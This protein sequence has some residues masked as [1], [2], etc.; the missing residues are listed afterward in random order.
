MAY[1]AMT[2]AV[3]ACIRMVYTAMGY[4]VMAYVVMVCTFMAYIARQSSMAHAD[5][6]IQYT[7]LRA[8]S[9]RWLRRHVFGRVC[10]ACGHTCARI[11][12]ARRHDAE[13]LDGPKVRDII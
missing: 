8:P 3:M 5:A 1:I 4:I 9:G 13:I 6:R 12:L 7:C 11:G 10:A 2:Y